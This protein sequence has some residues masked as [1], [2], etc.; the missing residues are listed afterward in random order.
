LR[1]DA[2]REKGEFVVLVEGAV[3]EGD[4]ADAEA[5]RILQILLKE[6]SVKQAANLAAQIT[7]RKKN[8]L[9]ERALA[10]KGDE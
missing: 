6:C 8:A 10:I 7:G 5:E 2:H 3:E 9:Y 1:A 4:A